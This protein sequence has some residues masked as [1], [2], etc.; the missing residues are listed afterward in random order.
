MED[1]ERGLLEYKTVGEFLIDIK[2]EFERRDEK[3]VKV[4]ELKKVKQEGKTIEEFVQEF[5]RVA[6][7]SRYK[8]RPLM[9]EFKRGI[10]RVI[11]RQLIETERSPTN[12]EQ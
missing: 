4:I 5:Q 10:N 6:R 7:D 11:R 1:L 12:I 8:E 2:K 9:K 3:L